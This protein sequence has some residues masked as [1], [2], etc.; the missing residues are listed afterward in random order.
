MIIEM[1]QEERQQRF[2]A[3]WKS[4]RAEWSELSPFP[5]IYK[6]MTGET[7]EQ[8]VMREVEAEYLSEHT[9]LAQWYEDIK[10]PHLLAL[11]AEKHL[12]YCPVWQVFELSYPMIYQGEY[13]PGYV[14]SEQEIVS[15]LWSAANQA[16]GNGIEAQ[17]PLWI[18]LRN[19]YAGA[20]STIVYPAMRYV[21]HGSAYRYQGEATPGVALAY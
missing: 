4:W 17:T 18:V 5:T 2:L 21:Y 20:C 1:P 6:R 13:N 3:L 19:G 10:A 11:T 9:L 15:G 12:W 16:V 14:H 7:L 8:M